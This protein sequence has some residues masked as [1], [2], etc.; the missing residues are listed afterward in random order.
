MRGGAA[1]SGAVRQP[2]SV[3]K[4]AVLLLCGYEIAAIASGRVPT[5]SELSCR[6]WAV[7]AVLLAAFAVDVHYLQRQIARWP[8][9]VGRA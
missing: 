5:V 1:G 6:Y 3:L 4:G 7:E 2:G 8:G 9:E